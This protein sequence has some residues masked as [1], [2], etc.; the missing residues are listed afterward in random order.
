MKVTLDRQSKICT[1]ER[2]HCTPKKFRIGHGWGVSDP[3]SLFLYKVKKELKLQGHN[4]VKKRM[5]KDGHLTDEE[6]QYL[7]SRNKKQ[8][9]MV[10]D[11]N[12]AIRPAVFDY[13]ETGKAELMVE[14]YK[15]YGE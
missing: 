3:N 8:G 5:C 15:T 7:R 9:I 4:L 2:D 13:N 12:Y 11:P 1:V 14:T 10:F 6:R